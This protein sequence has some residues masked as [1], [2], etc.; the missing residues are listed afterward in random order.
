MSEQCEC[1]LLVS[2]TA[3]RENARRIC[4]YVNQKVIA[5][6]KCDGYGV[7]LAAAVEAWRACGVTTFASGTPEEALALRALGC[8]DVLLLAPV[9]DAAIARALIAQG[10]ALTV[11]C[12][13][14]AARYAEAACGAQVRVHVAVD[15]GMGRFGVRWDERDRLAAIYRHTELTFEGIFSHFAASFEKGCRRTRRQLD[16]F[17]EATRCLERAGVAVG[18]RHIANSCAALRFPWTRLDAVRIGSALVGA[19]PCGVSVEL[20]PVAALRAQVVALRRLRRGDR[21]GYAGVYRVG[22]DTAAAVVALGER[23]GFGVCSRADSFGLLPLLRGVKELL[24]ARRAGLWVAW[25]ER[26]LPVLGRVGTQYTLIDVG[27]AALKAGD[28]VYAPANLLFPHANRHYDTA[29]FGGFICGAD[30]QAA[31]QA[32][33]AP[34]TGKQRRQHQ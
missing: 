22:R 11:G 19:L 3:L 18:L 4:S 33:K 17:L 32:P 16:R 10:V 8:A 21:V 31:S 34:G 29:P 27:D 28:F 24:C 14:D 25:E 23:Q 6:V 9:V 2:R 7:G 1:C 12:E 15:T 26:R 13:A 30:R 20:L 5:V